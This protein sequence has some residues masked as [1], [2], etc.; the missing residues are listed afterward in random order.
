MGSKLNINTKI[1]PTLQGFIQSYELGTTVQ[2][3]PL[4]LNVNQG[5]A[6]ATALFA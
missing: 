1:T 4:L 2:A 3:N 5:R 6:L